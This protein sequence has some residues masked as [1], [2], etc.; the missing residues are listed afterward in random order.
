MAI[1]QPAL[2]LMSNVKIMQLSNVLH[3]NMT[4]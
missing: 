1:A 2:T 3:I 4:A